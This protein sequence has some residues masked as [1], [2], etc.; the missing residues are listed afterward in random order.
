MVASPPPRGGRPAEEGEAADS[1]AGL[2]GRFL[3]VSLAVA[4]I[5]ATCRGMR[6]RGVEFLEP[7]A[8][9]PR[10]GVL[11]HLRDPEGSVVTLVG[12][13]RRD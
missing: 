3:G 4:D 9:M 1:D 11:A 7:P 5:D 13:P 10:G 8:V 6:S 2:V 12:A